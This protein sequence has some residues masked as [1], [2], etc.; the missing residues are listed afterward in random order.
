M[1]AFLFIMKHL[2]LLLLWLLTPA[3]NLNAEQINISAAN[4]LTYTESTK[5]ESA[6]KSSVAQ[7]PKKEVTELKKL[8]WKKA[9]LI[10]AIVLLPFAMLLGGLF[11]WASVVIVPEGTLPS[12]NVATV[13]IGLLTLFC[14]FLFVWS[15]W[16]LIKVS[17]AIKKEKARL[18]NL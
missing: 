9:W 10:A 15:I 6:Q 4:V 5:M 3:F 2:T 13:I 17:R 18:K 16:R 7:K 1:Y 11:T 14:I 12:V 8:R